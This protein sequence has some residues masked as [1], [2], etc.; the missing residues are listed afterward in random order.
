M[1]VSYKGG[2][3]FLGVPTPVP[4]FLPLVLD[5][6]CRGDNDDVDIDVEEHSSNSGSEE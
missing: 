5:F 2:A 4:F 6:A 1:R 3:T